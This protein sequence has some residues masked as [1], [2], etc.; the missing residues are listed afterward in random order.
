M[1]FERDFDTTIP[2]ESDVSQFNGTL[3]L[4]NAVVLHSRKKWNNCHSALIEPV[5]ASL[6]STHL[7]LYVRQFFFNPFTFLL[8]VLLRSGDPRQGCSRDLRRT[9]R[10]KPLF[11]ISF[12]GRSIEQVVP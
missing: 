3:G 2:S 10:V 12:F 1:I 8:T 6:V 7:R 9:P 11:R 5:T 4:S